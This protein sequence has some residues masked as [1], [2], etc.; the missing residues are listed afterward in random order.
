[1]CKNLPC[2]NCLAKIC[3]VKIYLAKLLC[4][5]TE[6]FQKVLCK[7]QNVLQIP[8]P[9]CDAPPEDASSPLEAPAT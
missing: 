8:L 5:F 4:E 9:P 2:E 7:N 6:P 1:M 3:L